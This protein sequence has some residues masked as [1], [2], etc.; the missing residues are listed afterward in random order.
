LVTDGSQ[1]QLVC[2]IGAGPAGLFAAGKLAEAGKKV[3]ILNRDI[4]YGGLAEYGIYVTK[5]KMKEGLRKQF[6]KILSHPNVLYYGNVM[7]S[8]NSELHL[9]D[10]KKIG[11]DAVVV[12]AG[13]QGT[14]K[15]GIPGEDAKGIYHAKD[16]VYH[17]N[18][19]PPFSE[20]EFPVGDKVAIIGVGN[21]MVD[22]AHWLTHIKEAKE[23]LAIARRGPNERAYNDKEMKAIA[24]NMDKEAVR[25]ELERIRPV[26]ESIGQDVE[27]T[28]EEL[29]KDCDEKYYEKISPTKFYF[30]FLY[31]PKRVITNENNEVAGLEVE[32]NNLVVE[33]G[34][35]LCKGLGKTEVISL[36]NVVFAI[37]DTVDGSLGLAVN[38][39]GEFIKNE[40]PYDDDPEAHQYEVFD[41]EKNE[42]VKGY[43]VVGWS[44]KASDG[45]VGIAKRDGETG[46]KYVLKYLGNISAP[47]TSVDDRLNVM[48]NLFAEK[49]LNPIDKHDIE[50]LEM[51]EKD[52]AQKR[53]LEFYK[54]NYNAD[55]LRVIEQERNKVPGLII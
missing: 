7:I 31:S 49:K 8:N 33:N 12:S 47:E 26:L 20:M 13:A 46:I 27:N 6:R 32:Q 24:Y 25:E 23:V 37:G 34:K 1:Q 36:T 29:T 21:V 19:L 41:P 55:M 17:Y 52:E 5:H 48:N 39:W 14:K 54:F 51:V 22:I 43:F 30:K 9:D 50:M 10:L 11:F 40:K 45:L 18:H 35:V 42:V 4:K 38:K 53:A 2:V 15:V 44:R 3:V 16:L 28:Y